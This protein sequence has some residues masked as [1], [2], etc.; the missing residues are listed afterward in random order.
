[1]PIIKLT[2][3]IKAEVEKLYKTGNYN[4]KEISKIY[5]VNPSTIER[6]LG[7]IGY[8]AKTQSELQRKY[9][10]VEDFF[11]IIDTEEKA[12]ILGLLYADGYNNTSK[13]DVCIS[14]KEEDV[15]ILNKI[16]EI[17]QPTKPLFYIDMSPENR[18]M[19]NSMNQYR[20]TINNKHISQK[21]VELGCGK[22]KTSVLKFP[23]KQQV[24][25][26]LQRHFIRGYFDGD[27]SI[28]KGKFPKIDIIS[29][30]EFL[31]DIQEIMSNVLYINKTKLN[32]SRKYIESNICCLQIS[33]RLKCIKFMEWM[34]KDATIYLK[35]KKDVFDNYY[36]N[37]IKDKLK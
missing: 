15:E 33:G 35:R 28:S 26:H 6:Y 36:I 31:Y 9:P 27:G 1:M 34:Y 3:D 13:N 24:P 8:K 11:D 32:W 21:L 18:G 17:I 22:A 16:T 37:V 30:P 4:F 7:K 20:L 19:K 23:T 12:Y 2:N 14:L 5:N 10:I 25:E 29:T